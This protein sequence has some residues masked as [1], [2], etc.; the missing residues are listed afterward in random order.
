MRAAVPCPRSAEV[1]SP[2]RP[3]AVPIRRTRRAPDLARLGLG[4]GYTYALNQLDEQCPGLEDM[5]MPFVCWLAYLFVCN[6][7]DKATRAR[8]VHS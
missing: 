7:S 5:D 8:Q 2:I 1:R 6:D 3:S 4:L